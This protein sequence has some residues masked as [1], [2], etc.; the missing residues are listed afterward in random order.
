M[1]SLVWVLSAMCNAG[2]LPSLNFFQKGTF[3]VDS[4]SLI[5]VV[6]EAASVVVLNETLLTGG[7]VGLKCKRFRLT[8]RVK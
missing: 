1:D 2:R 8:F 6:V 5:V 3:V 4:T 7:E